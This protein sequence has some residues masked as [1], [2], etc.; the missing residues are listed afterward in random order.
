MTE[1]LLTRRG[2]CRRLEYSPYT[3]TYLHKGKVV[4][5]AFSSKLHLENFTK[6]REKNYAM[7]YNNINKRFKCKVDCTFLSDFNLYQKVEKRGCYINFGGK[8]YTSIEDIPID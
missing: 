7:I 1:Q 2:V 8:I 4:N 5:L 3:F 6:L